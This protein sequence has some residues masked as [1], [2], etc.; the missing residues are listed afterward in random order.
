MIDA[1]G[2]IFGWLA[3]LNGETEWEKKDGDVII[4]FPFT[5]P[6]GHF[7]EISIHQLQSNYLRLSDMENTLSELFLQGMDINSDTRNIINEII[8]Q[9]KLKIEDDE[10]FT[11]V[12]M[13]AM[14]KAI[15]NMLQTLLSISNLIF[16]KRSKK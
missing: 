14:G 9:N 1:K 2:I 8:T 7:V 3:F 15:R 5:T 10:I 4:S 11:I 6:D 16:L 13:E 12:K